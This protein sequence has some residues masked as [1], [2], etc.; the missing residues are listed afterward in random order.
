MVNRYGLGRAQQQN[1]NTQQASDQSSSA[2]PETAQASSL[3][4]TEQKSDSSSSDP[5][6]QQ[7]ANSQ[8]ANNQSSNQ[9]QSGGQSGQGQP[10]QDGR[11]SQASRGGSPQELSTSGGGRNSVNWGGG[12]GGNWRTD[13][14]RILTETQPFSGPLTGGDFAPWSERLRDVEEMVEIQDLRNDIAAVRER[15]RVMRQ[16]FKRDKKKPDWAVVRGQVMN[17]LLEVRDR[18]AEELARRQASDNL[19]PL[20]RD[21]VP[22]RYSELVRRYYEQLGKAK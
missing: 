13:F 2:S 19:V 1:T 9:P 15:A 6:Q 11:S 14:D 4:Q 3:Q 16:E 7:N 22:D 21:P 10:N 5:T 8:Q 17:P 12:A 20:D 18:I